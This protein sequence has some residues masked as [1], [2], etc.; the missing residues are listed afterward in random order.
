MSGPM[1]VG[2]CLFLVRHGEPEE[3]ACGVCCGRL[4]PGLSALGLEQARRAAAALARARIEAL[5]SSPSRRALDTA[6]AISGD[7]GGKVKLDERLR[8]IDFGGFEGLTYEQ[9]ELHHPEAFRAWVSSPG[10]VRFPGGESWD[11][12]RA[13]VLPAVEAICTRE[14]GRRVAIVAHAGVVRVVLADVLGASPD[15][16]F[17][18]A[19]DHASITELERLGSVWTLRSTNRT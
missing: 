7:A 8:E 4:D 16:C 9:A 6:R 2:T 12:L 15:A 3:W 19:V 1:A 17:R 14:E 10:T 11:D 18:I 13:R 5:Y